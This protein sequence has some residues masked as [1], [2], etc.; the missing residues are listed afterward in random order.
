MKRIHGRKTILE[1]S[2]VKCGPNV[3][4][5]LRKDNRKIQEIQ[6]SVTLTMQAE[7]EW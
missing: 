3:I 6:T 2:N 5:G 7:Q 1:S 4:A